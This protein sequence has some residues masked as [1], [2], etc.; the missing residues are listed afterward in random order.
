[1]DSGESEVVTRQAKTFKTP[2]RALCKKKCA[3]ELLVLLCVRLVQAK[4]ES[5]GSFEIHETWNLQRRLY[6]HENTDIAR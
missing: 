6:K 5:E 3:M 2:F 1:M 4:H